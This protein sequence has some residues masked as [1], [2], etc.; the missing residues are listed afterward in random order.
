MPSL[1]SVLAGF[2]VIVILLSGC[3]S[4][5]PSPSGFLSDYSNLSSHPQKEGTLIYENPNAPLKGYT[6]CVVD[7][8]DV[9]F[10]PS[11]SGIAVPGYAISTAEKSLEE[12]AV[13]HAGK[14]FEL[15]KEPGAGVLRIRVAMTVL[16]PPTE[17]EALSSRLGTIVYWP[18]SALLEMET[19]DSVSGQ[20][21]CAYVD[22]SFLTGSTTPS[23]EEIRKDIE[24]RVAKLD[25]AMR[26]LLTGE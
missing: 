17:V 18:G 2:C 25:S 26:F 15:T 22:K 8:V 4:T 12:E 23:H 16:M 13:K 20:Q 5:T 24:A 1:V 19:V 7:P 21:I 10:G 9:C 6:K 14:Y 3:A 11:S